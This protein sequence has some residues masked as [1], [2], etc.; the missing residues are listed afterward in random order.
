[1]LCL[2]GFRGKGYSPGF[3]DN[4]AQIHRDLF[5]HPERRVEVVDGP[6]A[7]CSACPHWALSGCTLNGESS[8]DDMQAQDRHV[9]ALLGLQVGT[10]MRWGQILDRIRASVTGDMLPTICGRC[11]W[12]P[13]GYCRDGIEQLRRG[14]G[15]DPAELISIQEL[16]PGKSS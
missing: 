7:V 14:G 2:Q 1:M 8:E 3:I 13:L 6:D 12:L 10:R 5:V 16:R 11:R 15:H 9:L 4:L